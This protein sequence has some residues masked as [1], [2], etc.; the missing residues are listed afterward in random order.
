MPKR[1][2]TWT[3][4]LVKE[5]HESFKYSS[6]SLGQGAML[7]IIIV[8]TVLTAGAASAAVGSVAGAGIGSGSAMAAA[9]STAMVEAGTAVGAAAAGWGNVM[10]TAALTSMA[11]SGAVNVINNKGNFGLTLKD[12]FSRDGLTNT[13]ISALSAGA[14]N[15]VDSNWFQSVGGT[16]SGE[17]NVITAGPVKNPGYLKEM[18]NLSGFDETLLRSGTHVLLD[19]SI[20]TVVGGGSFG[21][22]F[23]NALGGEA[24]D[25]GAA[26]GNKAIG[27][28]AQGLGV[29]AAIAEKLVLHAVLGGLISK[30]KG[31]GFA[32]GAIAGGS[33]E[34]LAPIAN[35][36]LAEFVSSR[37]DVSDR[38]TQGTQYRIGTAQVIGLIAAGMAGG[39]PGTGSVIGG[40]GQKYNEEWHDPTVL[41]SDNGEPISAGSKDLDDAKATASLFLLGAIT[42]RWGIGFFDEIGGSFMSALSNMFGMFSEIGEGVGASTSGSGGIDAA[43]GGSESGIGGGIDA[44]SGTAAGNAT[45]TLSQGEQRAVKK[46]ENILNNFKDSDITGTLRDMAG[47]PVPKPGGGYWDHLK[48]MN[49][50]LRGLRNHTETLKGVTEPAA[51]ATRQRALDTI[52]RIESALNGAGI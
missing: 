28:L 3:G 13:T 2:E 43:I 31:E 11:S 50:L 18:F 52:S 44:A 40:A 15:Y 10:A 9:G 49:D 41:F 1:A 33:A 7:A 39:N 30:A 27:D 19:S 35:S 48:E 46:I 51:V 8:V 23:V 24:I 5:T 12:T 29:S 22:N 42:G 36:I 17:S 26:V 37:F 20:S 21:S 32:S 45:T 16:A 4:R 25:L 14:F 47:D 34:G 38:S 6:S